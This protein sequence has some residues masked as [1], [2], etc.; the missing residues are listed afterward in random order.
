MGELWVIIGDFIVP[1]QSC[2]LRATTWEATGNGRVGQSMGVSV[3]SVSYGSA[4][5]QD[6]G[7]PCQKSASRSEA[8][9][10]FSTRAN[11]GFAKSVKIV[12]CHL[13]QIVG[14]MLLRETKSAAKRTVP[15]A[16]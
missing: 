15:I 16:D 8:G 10:N 13:V 7:F 3:R 6:S 5:G 14:N 9:Q 2:F 1:H 11:S 4:E 12:G